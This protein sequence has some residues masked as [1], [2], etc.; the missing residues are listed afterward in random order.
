MILIYITLN[1]K[2]LHLLK[3]QKNLVD[4]LKVLN[5]MQ[6]FVLI[7]LYA[8]VTLDVYST[9]KN[10]TIFHL[11][12]DFLSRRFVFFITTDKNVILLLEFF[13][14][15]MLDG[16]IIFKLTCIKSLLKFQM[17]IA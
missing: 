8:L 5:I 10:Q 3:L 6:A 15:Q 14:H 12:L 7:I 9:N 11:S 2:L 17:R 4:Q 16:G 13:Y 1:N